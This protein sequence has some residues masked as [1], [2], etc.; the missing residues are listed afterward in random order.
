MG[1][2]IW[3]VCDKCK[4]VAFV[5]KSSPIKENLRVDNLEDFFFEHFSGD[6]G[7]DNFCDS[8]FMLRTD[9]DNIDFSKYEIMDLL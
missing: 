8:G 1:M 3:L 6:N 5:C 9:A 7:S 2:C 4:K